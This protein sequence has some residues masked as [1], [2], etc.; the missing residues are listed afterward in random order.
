MRKLLLT[1]SL[2]LPLVLAACEQE[3]PA[4]EAGE[5]VDQAVEDTGDAI[6]EATDS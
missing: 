5:N 2:T 1:L 6:D 4:E 3:G